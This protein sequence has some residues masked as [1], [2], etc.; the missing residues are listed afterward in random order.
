MRG[1]LCGEVW[2]ICM[3]ACMGLRNNVLL[4]V[5]AV[6]G[7]CGGEVGFW[8]FVGSWYLIASVSTHRKRINRGLSSCMYHHQCLSISCFTL[9]SVRDWDL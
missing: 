1:R 3:H 4:C 8:V 2:G 6:V 7:V 9:R 5:R